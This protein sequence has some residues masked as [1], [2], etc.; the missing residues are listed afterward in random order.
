MQRIAAPENAVDGDLRNRDLVHSN[1]P[2][3]SCD[4]GLSMLANNKFEVKRLQT[5]ADAKHCR[6]R[7]STL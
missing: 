5:D 4:I 3:R 2:P 6:A 1:S 7:I